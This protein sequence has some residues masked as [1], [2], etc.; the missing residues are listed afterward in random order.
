MRIVS[1]N[2]IIEGEIAL[3]TIRDF[4][5]KFLDR[6]LVLDGA[7]GTMLQKNGLKPG[8]SPE[9]LNATAPNVV[10]KVHKEYLEA[11][12][13]A[14]SSNTFGAN[15]KKWR[16]SEYSHLEIT[17]MGVK[18][19]RR[20]ADEHGALVGLNMGSTGELLEPMG[21]LSFD[22]AYEIFKEQAIQGE[23][24]GAD[25]VI[26]E[27]MTDLAE[28]RAALLAVKEN[29]E[30]P[31]V[32]CMTF[33]SNMR[34]FTGCDVRC[35]AVTLESLG[36]TAVG[37]NCS[38]GPKEIYPIACELIRYTNLPV[39]INANAG[40]PIAGKAEYDVLPEEF[41]EYAVKFAEIGVKLIGG[42]CGTT[43]D[44]IRLIADK[45]K[46]TTNSTRTP[47][48]NLNIYC[49]FG[50]LVKV[51]NPVVV[52][53]RLN[54]TGKEPL[55]NAL[56]NSD[57][58]Y[59]VALGLEQVEDG[60]QILNINA[61]LPEVDEA[62]TLKKMILNLQGATAT[63]LQIDSTTPHAIEAALRL[64]CGKTVI[65]SVNG[66]DSTLDSIL[67]IAAKYGAGVI[68]LTLDKNGIPETPIGR[69]KIAEKIVRAADKYGVKDIYID[70]L[71]LTVASSQKLA[72]VTLESMRLVRE[73]L[74]V[75]TVLG[76]SNISFGMPMR[77]ELNRVFLTGALYAGLKLA[78]I[79][80]NVPEMMDTVVSYKALT[81]QDDGCIG[82]I[83]RFSGAT[84]VSKPE[85]RPL[86]LGYAIANGIDARAACEVLLA[87]K[88]ALAI[89]EE[90]LIPA[91]DLVGE[92]Y[93]NGEVFLPQMIRSAES[94][95][96]A[97][98]FVRSH[99]KSGSTD[100][101]TV[102]VATVKG[103]VHDIGK[104]IVKTVLQSYG[105]K[106]VDL[107][108]DVSPEEVLEAART[109]SPQL[110]GL[111]ALMTTTLPNMRATIELLRSGGIRSTIC[112]G[113]AVL[114]PEC[115]LEMGADAYVIDARATTDL[116]R[117]VCKAK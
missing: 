88:D 116:A 46:N 48:D 69:F 76:V 35:M 5:A 94:A 67:P 111:S 39:A 89:L 3:M 114:T 104:N 7:M 2:V 19:A 4:K 82:Y 56:I 109:H 34:T 73:M 58:N 74:C 113:G 1:Q 65:N 66:D 70:C 57:F 85:E 21:T 22:E 98:E 101:G 25:F 97:F 36:A 26:V 60:A 37:I 8:E 33:E 28:M 24:S 107:G 64:Y 11:G 102:I 6:V 43:P 103:D 45:L 54:P 96:A 23:K 79:N 42:C 115:A 40:L 17:D 38:L 105:F 12:S 18:I 9:L 29:T 91:L 84:K 62:V 13:M 10:Y 75:P 108:K 117:K 100:S 80:P 106:V 44:Y 78:I 30:L 92:R 51:D 71:A 14:I 32:C 83:E 47:A 31:I 81:G 53:E 20:A 55:K 68:G 15:R 95:S 86:D 63:P 77:D 61:G 87:E 16:Y 59:V 50:N 93:S 72:D 52:G 90:N 110:I 99:I 41:A 27:T 112:V 49:S